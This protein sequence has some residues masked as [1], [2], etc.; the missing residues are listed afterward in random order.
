V[1]QTS[2][3]A[4]LVTGASSG[5][6]RAAVL[7]LAQKGYRVYAGVRRT[8]DGEALARLS[9]GAIFPLYIDVT[10]PACVADAARILDG[11]LGADGLY[12][13]VNNAGMVVAAPLEFVPLEDV[14][15]QFDVNVT[16]ALAVTQA[17][18]PLLRRAGGHIVNIGSVSGSISTPFT[19]PYNASKFAL[20]AMSDALRMELAPWDISVSIIEPGTVSTPLWQRS[21]QRIQR[22]EQRLPARATALYG[23][24]FAKMRQFIETARGVPPETV[25]S[26][27]VSALG[28]RRPRPYYP[29]GSDARLRL[30][31]ERLPTRVRDFLIATQL[32]KYPVRDP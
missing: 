28:S 22:L 17:V 15:E 19:G 31:L 8:E 9:G 25:A 5:I 13:L 16:G 6:G 3:P 18:L 26:V 4:I 11:E 1:V 32:P 30:A 21:L 2:P 7:T 14:R 20:R 12:G 10:D 23:P 29:V 24:V 27:I